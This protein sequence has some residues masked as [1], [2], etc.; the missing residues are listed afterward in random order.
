MRTKILVGWA[1]TALVAASVLAGFGEADASSEGR[2]LRVECFVLELDT[3]VAG[4]SQHVGVAKLTRTELGADTLF[5]WDLH[6]ALDDLRV[7][8]VERYTEDGAK[9]VWRE[10]GPGRG[11]TLLA[12]LA[13]DADTLRVVDWSTERERED[14]HVGASL[15]LPL[16]ELELARRNELCDGVQTVF[17][18]LSREPEPRE[19][20]TRFAG[21]PV[22]DASA[23][24]VSEAWRLEREVSARRRD[25]THAWS[26]R[27]VGDELV[28]Y[29][30][31]PGGLVARRIEAAEYERERAVLD[32]AGSEV[33]LAAVDVKAE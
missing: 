2:E 31:Q 9:L 12:E 17:D 29:A 5:E 21:V 26:A 24:P 3:P 30:W 33:G 23:E 25:G 10:V 15:L 18:P 16:G 6:F 28:A 14:V 1:V 13:H 19:S 11:R 20:S 27:F 8:H 7:L 4:T 22:E 32:A